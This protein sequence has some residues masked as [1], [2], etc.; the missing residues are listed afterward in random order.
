VP[1]DELLVAVFGVFGVDAYLLT[2]A[3]ASVNHLFLRISDGLCRLP[4]C[5]LWNCAG[6]PRGTRRRTDRERTGRGLWAGD[7][8]NL[9]CKP[10]HTLTGG[11]S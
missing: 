8:P 5:P 2:R 4:P 9:I 3:G 11:S 6:M 10:P 1:A 7:R